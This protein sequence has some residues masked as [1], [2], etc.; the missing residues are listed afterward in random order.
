M[1]QKF[2]DKII[3]IAIVLCITTLVAFAYIFSHSNKVSNFN[4][5]NEYIVSNKYKISFDDSIFKVDICRPIPTLETKEIYLQDKESR[6]YGKTLQFPLIPTSYVKSQTQLLIGDE[7][8]TMEPMAEKSNIFLKVNGE[9]VEGEKFE[10]TSI[11]LNAGKSAET[12][13]ICFKDICFGTG[14]CRV[15][16]CARFMVDDFGNFTKHIKIDA[17]SDKDNSEFAKKYYKNC[18]E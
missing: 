12:Y 9:D 3:L 17:A 11:D 2:Q 5:E 18:G 8:K 1:K 4:K 6:F 7:V 13:A 14:Y 10:Y 16:N 15:G